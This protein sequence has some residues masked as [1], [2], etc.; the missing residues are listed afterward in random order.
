MGATRVIIT[1]GAFWACFGA[2]VIVFLFHISLGSKSIPIETVWTALVAPEDG[3]FE[4]VIVRELRM[5][6]ALFVI[7]VG[8]S[9]SVAG[10]ILQGVT[11][12][13]LAEIEILGLGAGASFAVVIGIGW[14]ELTSLAYVPLASALGTLGGA[15]LVLVIA[16]A[17]PGGSRPLNLVLAGA[18]VASF[19]YSLQACAFLLQGDL[20]DEFRLW[21]SGSFSGRK[22]ESFIWALPWFVVGLSA[23]LLIS[24]QI[25]TLAMGDETAVGLGLNILR[26]KL[27]AYAIVV[28]LTAASIA[29]AGPIGFVGLV[30]PHAV[31][32]FAGA[33]YRLIVPFSMLVGG[34]FLLIADI[35]ARLVLAPLEMSTGII[36]AMFGA[37][38][39]IWLVRSKL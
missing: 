31:R 18:A 14:F 2:V 3:A 20:F 24:R 26:I 36:T 13:P 25:T 5:P 6:R 37:P 32:L 30:I 16:S 35:A 19:L 38:V 17:A 21:L 15:A 11:N 7:F 33:D 23:A 29:M 27:V 12:N 1:A 4:H 10:A 9:L 28:A 22:M 8:A 34:C 39:F